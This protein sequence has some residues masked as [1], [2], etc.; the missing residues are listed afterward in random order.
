[1]G[2][3]TVLGE[4]AFFHHPSGP[5]VYPG[6]P[7]GY[8]QRS[9]VHR[10]VMRGDSGSMPARSKDGASGDAGGRAKRGAKVRVVVDRRDRANE[11]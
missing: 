4:L 9:E 1:V 11:G 5:W 10:R 3:R 8:E 7:T 2:I 6:S